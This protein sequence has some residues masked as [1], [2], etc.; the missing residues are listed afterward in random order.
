MITIDGIVYDVP[1]ISLKRRADFLDKSAERT[2]DGV[3]HRELIGVFKNY[4]LQFGAPTTSAELSA[5]Q[6]LWAKLSEAT[7][8]HTVV[9]PD[10]LGDYTFTAYF[11]NVTD[12]LRR[13][14]GGVNYWKGLTANFIAKEPA[15]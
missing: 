8:F 2:V 11:S 13:V 15:A 14:R 3:L 6:A 1:I 5:Y 7:D 10:E 9:V 12:E 4:Q